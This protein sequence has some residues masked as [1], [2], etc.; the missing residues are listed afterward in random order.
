ML[1]SISMKDYPEWI[2][3]EFGFTILD[4]CHHLGAEVFSR[5]L[6]KV[7]SKYIL[8]L[9]AT[10]HRTDGLNKV[11]E[12]YLGPYVF[13]VKEQ[14]KRKVR[15]NMIYYNNP[16]PLYSGNENL[17]N[18]KPCLARMTNNITEFNRRNELILEIMRRT[19]IKDG[20]H[21][22]ALSDRREHLKYLHEQI[23]ERKISSVGYYVGGMKQ[24][25]L[26]ESESKRFVLGTFTMAAEALDIA[27]LN[28][29]LLMTS[30][31]GGS[32]HT[33]SC[34]RI[35]RKD[36]GEITPT[37]WDIVDDFSTYKNQAKKRMEYYKKQNYDIFKVFIN[38]HDD[39]PIS[40]LLNNLDKMESV[41][42]RK[43]R[44][45]LE[46]PKLEEIE[47]LIKED[48]DY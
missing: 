35:L 15:V 47:C 38:D 9:S 27:T 44:K 14:N 2:F 34:G 40:E 37:I 30:H 25:D 7:N 20:T 28:T 21:V 26:K 23:D 10:P 5:A 6:P 31:S 16:N 17:P 22:L 24:K 19:L 45:K 39:T 3:D 36:H 42:V 18:G 43:E 32:V 48:D 29:L 12:W 13:A 33:Q 4:E 46:K 41:S 8:G 1:Q 11:F